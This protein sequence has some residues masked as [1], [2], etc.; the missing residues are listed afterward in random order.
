MFALH[1]HVLL[2]TY[3]GLYGFLERAVNIAVQIRNLPNTVN[4]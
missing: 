4:M 3:V 2:L 1:V